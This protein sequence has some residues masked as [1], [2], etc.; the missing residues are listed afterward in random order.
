MPICDMKDTS[1]CFAKP[2]NGSK[3]AKEKANTDLQTRLNQLLQLELKEGGQS[4]TAE[5][6]QDIQKTVRL[7]QDTKNLL[8]QQV[9]A[10]GEL[11]A[12]MGMQIKELQ[13]L[14]GDQKLA[15]KKGHASFKDIKDKTTIEDKQSELLLK[16][17]KMI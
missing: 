2:S 17:A 14:M 9:K 11:K 15:A 4:A 1:K 5:A 13:D 7:I 3:D 16:Y 6:R 8:G 12:Q 10:S